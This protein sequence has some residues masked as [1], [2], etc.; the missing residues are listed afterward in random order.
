MADDPTKPNGDKGG[1]KTKTVP[2]ASLD[3][4]SDK[5]REANEKIKQFEAEK[6]KAAEE[7][8]KAEAEKLKKDGE[9]Q[10]LVEQQEKTIADLKAKTAQANR[11]MAIR[12]VAQKLGAKDP[13]DMV[14]LIGSKVEVSED[15]AIDTSKVEQL[16]TEVKTAKGYLFGEPEKPSIGTPGG[17]PDGGGGEQTF[18]RS[19]LSD[20][21]FYTEHRDDIIKAQKEGRIIDDLSPAEP[22]K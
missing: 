8:Q 22:Q 3:A 5:L 17:A 20:R 6:A 21:A 15:G 12:E 4:V 2:K 9:L 16:I 19:Q 1:D 10:T 11:D 18:K 13:G 7:A 14:T